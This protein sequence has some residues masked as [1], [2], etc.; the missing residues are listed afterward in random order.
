MAA[1]DSGKRRG[2]FDL[3]KDF[4]RILTLLRRERGYSQKM[5]AADLGISQA[6]LSHYEKGIREC[7]LDFVLRVADY[8]DVSCDYL[9]GRTLHRSGAVLAIQDVPTENAPRPKKGSDPAVEYNRRVLINSLSIVFG[10]LK[11]INSESLNREISEFLYASVYKMFRLLYSSNPKNSQDIFS[12][13]ALLFGAAM[14]S[15]MAMAEAKSRY[16]LSGESIGDCVGVKK[17]DI[18]AI[19][20]EG[21]AKEF[22]QHAPAL[23]DLIEAAEQSVKSDR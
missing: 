19:T 10:L 7:G 1:T 15:T 22:P 11:K 12:L 3:N 14:N 8:Y 20:M 5:V 4:P 13:D 23:M 2:K 9:L 6:L 21:L 17:K 16:I 18:P